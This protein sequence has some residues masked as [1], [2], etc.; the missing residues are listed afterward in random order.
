MQ[1]IAALTMTIFSALAA[2]ALLG[3][4]VTGALVASSFT[5]DYTNNQSAWVRILK[6]YSSILCLFYKSD[7]LKKNNLTTC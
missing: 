1:V 7:S 2:C 4:E 3:L 6:P 5:K